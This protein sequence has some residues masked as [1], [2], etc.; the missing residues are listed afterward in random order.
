M[1][2]R[3]SYPPVVVFMLLVLVLSGCGTAAPVPTATAEI[4]PTVPPPTAIPPPTDIPTSAPTPTPPPPTYPPQ[5]GYHSLLYDSNADTVLLFG[6]EPNEG[7]FWDDAWSYKTSTNT[8]APLSPIFKANFATDYD[9]KADRVVFYAS[10]TMS[11]PAYHK[12]R[13]TYVYDPNN[14]KLEKVSPKETPFGYLGSQLVYDSKADRF[15]LFGGYDFRKDLL[16]DETWS[17]DLNANT[18]TDRKPAQKPPGRNFHSMIYI[19]TIDRVLLFGGDTA[20]TGVN[21]HDTDS[22]L[23]DYNRNSWK[24]LKTPNGP[25]VRY[26]SSMVYV[27]SIDRVLMYGGESAAGGG[28]LGDFWSFNPK[29]LSWEELQQPAVTPGKR[30]WHA[31]AYDSKADKVVLFGGGPTKV[32]WTDETWIYDPQ[33]NT[34]TNVTPE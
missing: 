13:E 5:R 16:L 14:D 34:W 20:S 23:Y 29:T 31:M 21:P 25:P 8:W 10:L 33:A 2:R 18:W 24:L 26:Y 11:G 19:P 30:A 28:I 12:M 22:W 6:G 4:L 7:E 27:S 3:P 1:K 15:I 32:P 9:S 17:Y